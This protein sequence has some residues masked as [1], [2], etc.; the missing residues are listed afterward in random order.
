MA[1]AGAKGQWQWQ[2]RGAGASVAGSP[3]LKL[4]RP[5]DCGSERTA[6]QSTALKLPPAAIYAARGPWA[7]ARGALAPIGPPRLRARAHPRLLLPQAPP[8]PRLLAP[9]PRVPSRTRPF[10]ARSD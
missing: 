5:R 1:A 2:V 6:R 10:T 7:T 4:E 8:L 9:L 3:P